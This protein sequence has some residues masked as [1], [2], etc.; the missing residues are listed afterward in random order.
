MSSNTLGQTLYAQLIEPL[1]PYL[2]PKQQ[3]FLAPDGELSCLPFQI[4]PG[5]TEPYLMEEYAL[6]YITVGR[7]LLRFKAAPT[8]F[9]PTQ[10]LVLADPDY[11]LT[12]SSETSSAPPLPTSAKQEVVEELAQ[13]VKTFDPLPGTRIEGETVA[14]KLGVEAYLAEKALKSQLS[15]CQSPYILHM[16][17]HGYF[18]DS[19]PVDLRSWSWDQQGAFFAQI[20]CLGT[21]ALHNPAVRSGLAF[22]GANTTLQGEA[23]PPEA[24]DGLLT[25]Q[26][27]ARLNLLATQLVVASACETALGS[28]LSGEGVLGL[29]RAFVLAG[30]QTLVISLWKVNDIATAILMERFYDNL[31]VQKMG[32]AEALEEAQYYVRDLSIEQMGPKWLSKDTIDSIRERSR[33][34]ADFLEDLNQRRDRSYQPFEPPGFWGAFICQGNPDPLPDSAAP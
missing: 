26:D 7:D 17:T 27:A 32:R 31:L 16:A 15:R 2:T 29:R 12:R 28:V 1:A 33:A 24:E 4:L 5:R 22:A 10:P 18:L 23:L 6:R 14:A 3:V 19:L 8:T 25:T 20:G 11:D 30:A 34:T 21:A 13:K 9:Q